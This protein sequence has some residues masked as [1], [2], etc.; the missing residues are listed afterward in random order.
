GAIPSGCGNWKGV[1]TNGFRETDNGSGGTKTFRYFVSQ[2]LIKAKYG[3][4]TGQQVIPICAGGQRVVSGQP[5][6]CQNDS[7]GG[8]WGETLDVNGAF[9]GVLKQATCNP[10]GLWW[11]ILASFQDFNTPTAPANQTVNWLENP[12]VKAWNSC[13][14]T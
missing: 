11:G 3:K 4:N 6:P 7:G 2:T 12:Y 14:G 5:V 1:G 9:A 13:T 8:W 10:D